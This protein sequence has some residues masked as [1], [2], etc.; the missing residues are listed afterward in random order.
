M[1][2]EFEVA[3]FDWDSGNRVKCRKH[4]V[5]VAD[6]EALFA[7]PISV[8]PAPTHSQREE[9]FKAVGSTKKGRHIVLVFT[10][11]HRGAEILIRPISARY[12]HKKE[13]Q[14]YEKETAQTFQQQGGGTFRR[15][16]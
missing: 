9:R 12:M 10:L 2:T 6:I 8:F 15:R 16:G 11:R 7:R 5:S 1:V 13:V 14:H 3:G 4:G